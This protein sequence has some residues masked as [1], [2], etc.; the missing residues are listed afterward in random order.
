LRFGEFVDP[1]Q[2]GQTSGSARAHMKTIFRALGNLQDSGMASSVAYVERTVTSTETTSDAPL[3]SDLALCL[4]TL[5]S[6]EE[7]DRIGELAFVPGPR[8]DG[9]AW[10][11]GRRADDE[12]RAQYLEFV[13]Q[14]PSRTVVT[15]PLRASKISRRQLEVRVVGEER[16]RIENIGRGRLLV[17]DRL[18]ESAIVEPGDLVE[19]GRRLL[20]RVSR[21]PRSPRMAPLDDSL[22]AFPFG[23]SDGHGLVGE[24]PAAWALRARIQFLARRDY[25]VLVLGESGT[26]KELVAGAIHALSRRRDRE[27]VSRNAATIPASLI[28]AEMFGNLRDYP[29]PGMRERPGLIGQ[30]HESTLFLDEIGELSH[31]LQAHLL[32]VMD[33]GEYQR[34]GD[35]RRRTADVRLIAATNRAPDT[36]KHDFLGRFPLRVELT[37]LDQRPDDVPL[38]VRHLLARFT[39]EEPELAAELGLEQDTLLPSLSLIKFLVRR[40]YVAHVRELASILWRSLAEFT[41]PRLR[42][43]RAERVSPPDDLEG[44]EQMDAGDQPSREAVLAALEANEWVL[45]RAWRELG[46]RNRHQL[47]RLMTRLSIDRPRTHVDP[48]SLTRAEI[49][50]ALQRCGG[51]KQRAWRELGLRSRHQLRRLLERHEIEI[52]A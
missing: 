42:V 5:W 44:L 4:V 7:P 26:G 9:S 34:L 35:S 20:L 47:S 49:I 28:D 24:S 2:P 45:E 23:R 50:A 11:L 40:S 29:N 8:E 25:H 27:L 12:T 36:L 1:R 46:L 22:W 41:P 13:R 6:D 10:L 31:D 14:R 16:L 15:G 48:S 33:L 17:N 21:R 18:V 52:D 3:E 43:P 38:L 39:S 30:A 51:V 32:R 19:L 37:P